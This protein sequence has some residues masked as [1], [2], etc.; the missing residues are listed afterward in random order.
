MKDAERRSILVGLWLQREPRLR[1]GDGVIAFYRWLERHRPELLNRRHSD[2]YQQLRVD[3]RDQIL[4]P[5]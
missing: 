2:P 5:R 1:T 3:L 4:N